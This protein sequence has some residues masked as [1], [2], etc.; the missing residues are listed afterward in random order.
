MLDD[1]AWKYEPHDDKLL[2]RSGIK[3]DDLSVEFIMLVN[4]RNEVVQFLS[5]LP[6]KMPEDCSFTL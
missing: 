4:P 3:G 1:R 2:I 6:F 5:S